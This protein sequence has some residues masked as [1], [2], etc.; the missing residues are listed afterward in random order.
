MLGSCTLWWITL[1]L[2]SNG[3]TIHQEERRKKKNMRAYRDWCIFIQIF[4]VFQRLLLMLH[5]YESQFKGTIH[6]QLQHQPAF[7]VSRLLSWRRGSVEAQQW[8]LY[9]F[10][11][12]N[13]KP[14]R[15]AVTRN[16]FV[17]EEVAQKHMRNH[18]MLHHCNGRCHLA[19]S[20][21]W[22]ASPI[23][24]LFSLKTQVAAVCRITC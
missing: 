12:S 23:A 5:C 11:S 16:Q 1:W 24:L 7:L 3:I 9:V 10:N 13:M 17:K 20:A 19:Q 21:F 4:T 6:S 18:Y 15:A 2:T 14:W 8:W 22:L